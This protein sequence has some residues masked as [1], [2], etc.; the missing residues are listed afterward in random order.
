MGT[1][2]LNKPAKLVQKFTQYLNH[3]KLRIMHVQTLKLN[4]INTSLFQ[5]SWRKIEFE[6]T[7]SKNIIRNIKKQENKSFIEGFLFQKLEALES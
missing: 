6:E 3:C 2:Y 1:F 7:H 4:E 5:P